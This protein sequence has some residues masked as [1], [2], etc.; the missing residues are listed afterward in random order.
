MAI[1]ADD[2]QHVASKYIKPDNLRVV[3]VGDVSKIQSA[4]GKSAR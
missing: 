1:T 3:A 2:I 4:L